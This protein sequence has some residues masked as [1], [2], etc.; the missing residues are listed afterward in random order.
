[1]TG[2]LWAAALAA[3]AASGLSGLRWLRV[4]QREHYLAGAAARF[5]WRWW[6]GTSVNR[7]VWVVAAVAAVV[8][9][10]FP[11]VAVVTA[12][13]TAAGP[14]GLSLKGR[15]SPLRWTPRLR[16]LAVTWAVLQLVAIAGSVVLGVEIGG[17]VGGGAALAG[18]SVLAVPVLVDAACL[19]AGPLE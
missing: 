9:L 18:L 6:A 4:S 17:W 1:M 14:V 2:G 3:M 19:V 8:S 11:A 10:A 5:G 15:T 12:A 13:A 7:L 16:R